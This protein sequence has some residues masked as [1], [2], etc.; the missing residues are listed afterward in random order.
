M[1]NTSEKVSVQWLNVQIKC[2]T[3]QGDGKV[4]KYDTN[5]HSSCEIE[6]FKVM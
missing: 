1:T 6:D 2:R 5:L 3:L 4:S